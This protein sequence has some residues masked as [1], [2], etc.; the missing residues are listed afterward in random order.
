MAHRR[1]RLLLSASAAAAISGLLLI[2]APAV[3]AEPDGG[4]TE[5]TVRSSAKPADGDDRAAEADDASGPE[6]TDRKAGSDTDEAPRKPRKPQGDRMILDSPDAEAAEDPE[7]P[8]EAADTE[9]ALTETT[10][11]DPLPE[12]PPETSTVVPA[13]RSESTPTDPVPDT[14]IDTTAPGAAIVPIAT[15]EATEANRASEAGDRRPTLL[16]VVGSLVLNLLVGFI[17]VIDG[18]PVLPPNSTVTVRTSSL[19]LPIGGGRSVQADWYFPEEYSSGQLDSATRLVYLQHGFLASGPLYSYTAARLAERTGAIVVAPSLTS[20]FFAAD[21]AWVGGSTM[22]RAVADL[23][24]GDRP[25]LTQSASAAAGYV[26]RLPEKFVL[27]GHSAG[28][29]LVTSAAGFMADNG[30]IDALTGIVMLDGVEPA[31][32]RLVGSALAKLRG[33]SD[34]PVYLISSERYF[35]SRGGDMADKLQL[36]RPGRFNGVGL[37]GG[38]HI[39]YM[40]GGNP[41]VQFGEYVVAGFSLRRNVDAA[42]EITIGWVDDLFAGTAAGVYGSPGDVVAVVTPS[43]TATAVVL[44]LGEPARPVWPPLLDAALTAV[45]DFAGRHLFVYEPLRGYDLQ[46]TG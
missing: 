3:S 30:A 11:I 5:T 25:A 17:Q 46:P 16:N 33:S 34:R 35:W 7:T 15:V 45:F 6:R 18:P 27:V 32:S 24:A 4:G 36:A 41:L 44:P 14:D 23:F 42:S 21:A 29:S 9:R 26:V 22:H 39:D 20:N 19:T 28:G 8:E 10:Q 43:G 31:G 38:L 37:Q 40:E 12:A 1:A 13:E 2:A